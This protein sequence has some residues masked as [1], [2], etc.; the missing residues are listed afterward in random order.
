MR[1][2]ALAI[3]LTAISTIVVL[4]Y[5]D[6]PG[7]S[8]ATSPPSAQRF[9]LDMDPANFPANTATTLGTTEPCAAMNENNILDADEDFVD[10]VEFDV[11]VTGIPVGYEMLGYAYTLSYPAPQTKIVY[12]NDEWLLWSIPGWV[13]IPPDP[14]ILDTDGTLDVSG[15]EGDPERAESG[16]GVL[17]RLR[18]ETNPGAT[19]GVFPLTLSNAA[20]IDTAFIGRAPDA[21]DN[22]YIN[23]N[24]GGCPIFVDIEMVSM[25]LTSAN[26]IPIATN[27]T[28]T[29]D[30]SIRN[31]SP[32]PANTDAGTALNVPA[33]CTVN[34]LTGTVVVN[35]GLGIL[36]GGSSVNHQEAVN[37]RC[38]SYGSFQMPVTACGVLND[39]NSLDLQTAN[40][41]KTQNLPFDVFVPPGTDS[42]SDRVYDLD[43]FNCGVSTFGILIFPE[44]LNGLDDDGDTEID[45]AL[46]PG[47]ETWDCD[48]DGYVGT[49]EAH[50]FGAGQDQDR[51]GLGSWPPD[52]VSG[53][54]PD[55]TDRVNIG[56]FITFLLP[57]RHLNTNVGDNPGNVRW[58]IVPGSFPF[59]YDINVTDLTNL[60]VV[61]PPLFSGVRAFNGLPCSLFGS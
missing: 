8:L 50:V 41:C 61:K 16:S 12:R 21:L 11:T 34:G 33:G 53:G 28:V 25:S 17:D 20:H 13:R 32:Y 39:P 1:F 5:A 19:A 6:A 36:S 52:F 10:T 4:A 37:L 58:D 59:P 56:D 31:N 45:E 15:A 30:E 9:S 27:N 22:A 38:N 40:N 60:I 7:P 24:S 47:S 44:R 57:V 55:S 51:C 43:E 3:C 49:T 18:I 42:D 14:F 26:P 46:P 2:P 54:V 23:L 29:V 48:G 35:S